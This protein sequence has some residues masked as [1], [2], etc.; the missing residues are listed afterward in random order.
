MLALTLNYV[1]AVCSLDLYS[2]IS[3]HPILSY[4]ELR[5]TYP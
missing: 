3:D 4:Q 5:F 2:Q 1:M